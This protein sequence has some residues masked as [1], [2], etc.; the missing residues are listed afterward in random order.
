MTYTPAQLARDMQV[1]RSKVMTW[2]KSGRLAAVNVSE[3]SKPQYRITDD[4]V[5]LFLDSRRVKVS[6]AIGPRRITQRTTKDYFGT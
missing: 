3:G 1:G 4:A 5:A 2:I 6:A